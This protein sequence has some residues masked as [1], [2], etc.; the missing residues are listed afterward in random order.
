MPQVCLLLL[1]AAPVGAQVSFQYD[2]PG[3]LVSAGTAAALPPQFQLLVPF[4][5]I[6]APNGILSVSAPVTGTGPL[7]Y[8][9]LF[10]GQPIANA[11]NATFLL[12]NAG[13]ADLG[14]YQLV[15][16]NSGGAATSAV[17]T[18][19]FDTD[20][21]G[22]P[23]AWQLE[24]FGHLGVDPNADSNGAGL[25][26][27][28]QYL[29]GTNPTN[30]HS[31][32]PRLYLS[33]TPG[34][35]AS[36]TPLKPKYQLND[37]VQLVA[38]PNPGYTFLGWSGSAPNSSNPLT[39]V[40]DGTKT[41]RACF[42]LPLA[43]A[44]DATN[45][46]WT[47]GGDSLWFGETNITYDGVSAAQS[48]TVLV[49]QQSWLQTT[50]AAPNPVE[51]S[52]AWGVS[53]EAGA[54]FL[55]LYL[56]GN[57][58]DGLSGGQG[59]PLW[60]ARTWLLPPTA[61]PKVLRW[62]YAQDVPDQDTGWID[63]D[64][65]WLDQVRFTPVVMA[66]G[67]SVV[68][69]WG[70]NAYSQAAVPPG[71]SGVVA[72]AAGQNHSLAL[73]N[74]GTLVAW[75][76]D[77][78][79][80]TDVPPEATNVTAIA[81]GWFHNLALKGDGTLVTWGFHE[82]AVTAAPPG[83][84]NLVAV[85]GGA[86]HSLALQRNGTVRAWGDDSGGQ[87][88]AGPGL[89]NVVAI[90]AGGYFSLAL[91]GNGTVVAWGADDDG[92]ADVP[93]GLT[94]VVAIAAGGYFSLALKGNGTVVA[95]GADDGGQTNV[96]PGLTNVVAIAAGSNYSLALGS[97]GSLVAWGDDTYGQTNFSNLPPD[98]GG[99]AAIAAGGNHV[100]ALLGN[101]SPWISQQPVN[102]TLYSG[103]TAV[104]NAG[105]AGTSP[106]AYQWR[107][108]GQ[109]IA[110]ATNALL[111]LT[112]VQSSN[113]GAY[114]VVVTNS[115]GSVTSSN[116]TLTVIHAAPLITGQPGSVT[117][118]QGQAALFQ[119]AVVGSLPLSYQWF[120]GATNLPG[121]TSPT[122]SVP[123][124]TLDQV[125]PYQ[126]IVSNAYGSATSAVAALAFPTTGSGLSFSTF[127]SF[128]A[129]QDNNGNALD[130]ANPV[131]G[132]ILGPDGAL[133]GTT[134]G[135]GSNGFGTVFRLTP[136]GTLTILHSFGA[137]QDA[138]G[139]ALDGANPA[140]ALVLGSDRKL[141]G[142]T[143]YG[144][145]NG[146][147]TV[148]AITADGGLTSLYHFGAIQ[149][150]SGN[151]LDGANPVAALLLG[152]D[153]ALYGTASSGG[154][155]FYGTVFR[156]TTNGSMTT[157]YSFGATPTDGIS[158]MA[159]LALGPGGALYGTASGG[160]RY[161]Y[162]TV[163][164][165]TTE[166]SMTTVY[167]FGL[168]QAN[169]N[170]LDGANPQ[171][172]VLLDTDGLLYGTTQGGGADTNGTIFRLGTNGDLATLHYFG[173]LQGPNGEALDGATPAGG[174][175][176]SSDGS[177]YGVTSSGG[178]ANNGTIFQLTPDATFTTLYRF[179]GGDDGA[180]PQG[181]LV[182]ASDGSFYGVT[183]SGGTNG[184]GTIFRFTLT[185]SAPPPLITS[186]LLTNGVLTFT[187]RA[188]AG[189]TYQ[190]QY[191]SN[192]NQPT[193]SNL[194][195][196]IIAGGTTASASDIVTNSQRFYRIFSSP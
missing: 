147:G 122:L 172:P 173:S 30:A 36:V 97:D 75:G 133:Y 28:Q 98:S 91:K 174:L 143:P 136:Q 177:L 87:T 131:A 88:D 22:L 105:A 132:L 154:G 184:D 20:H 183:E 169:G 106:L 23:D 29:D 50:I 25:S 32:L 128:G 118:L 33:R 160:G 34:G 107:F 13:S 121:A 9:W 40:M 161:S 170:A 65:G 67:Q 27:Y 179:S 81:S 24:Y 94:N 100:L 192:L 134:S 52:A 51:L 139:N 166:G 150:T 73:K 43:P 178:Q 103:V 55:N 66:P 35:T 156:T 104:F 41:I 78:D 127:Y 86:A 76:N 1:A 112:N 89:S 64:T 54:N 186:V 111:V 69:A 125:G 153:A 158:P 164:R 18:V 140:A 4:Y 167:S 165:T 135:S 195:A 21:R 59:Q 187:W 95:W 62:V 142:T 194:G 16:S 60:Q 39:L 38:V 63:L 8:Q 68:V 185:Q 5:V 163:F 82:A 116:A 10:N 74:D 14:A 196:P 79:G 12:T 49:G 44:L 2:L 61:G 123:N 157:L 46:A 45:L 162:G 85:A 155:Y 110:G 115:L 90:A 193:W 92:Q 70:D 159:S 190:V 57:L 47:T 71:L 37:T 83:L 19:S 171:A 101:G 6:A 191:T 7:S 26:Y 189:Q 17:I 168:F 129:I 11:T 141:Y 53:S 84:S 180:N 56:N 93:P 102:R 176:R 114:S 124:A 113:A 109:G 148:F 119:V 188:V 138:N 151:A 137:I 15:A 58:F 42:G 96:P 77:S 120:F 3:D 31:I 182:Q 181:S 130:G 108:N 149:D 152:P 144:G 48:G 80:E 72:L 146:F 117:I 145:S 126:V 175:V 99:F